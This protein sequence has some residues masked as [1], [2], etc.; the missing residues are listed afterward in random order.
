MDGQH[1]IQAAPELLA[2][3]LEDSKCSVVLV[4]RGSVT[5]FW[6][7]NGSQRR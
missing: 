1:P 3:H 4:G 5:K 6:N 7:Q 2:G